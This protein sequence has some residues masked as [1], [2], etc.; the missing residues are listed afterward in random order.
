MSYDNLFREIIAKETLSIDINTL[1][2]D[3]NNI[4]QYYLKN[5]DTVLDTYYGLIKLTYANNA[6]SK[7]YKLNNVIVDTIL[8]NGININN[9]NKNGETAIMIILNDP[10]KYSK[11]DL[12]LLAIYK[13]LSYDINLL[14]RDNNGETVINRL[15]IFE[16]YYDRPRILNFIIHILT[17]DINIT[18]LKKKENK[19]QLILLVTMLANERDEQNL[20]IL[21][22]AFETKLNTNFNSNVYSIIQRYQEITPTPIS[23]RN[24]MVYPR[25]SRARTKMSRL[26][27]NSVPKVD[28]DLF[29]SA[30]KLNDKLYQDE[31]CFCLEMDIGDHSGPMLIPVTRFGKSLEEGYYGSMKKEVHKDAVFTWYYYEPDS[32]FVLLSN[33]TFIAKNKVQ[34]FLLLTSDMPR[35]TQIFEEDEFSAEN[36]EEDNSLDIIKSLYYTFK[37]LKKTIKED[38]KDIK[39]EQNSEEEDSEEE[40]S[41]EEDSE[42]ESDE[43][44]A[45]YMDRRRYNL[46]SL[47]DFEFLD[48]L[49]E[50][51]E[52]PLETSSV[53]NYLRTTSGKVLFEGGAL[54]YLDKQIGN[55]AREKGYEVLILTHQS[56]TY[57]RLV[58]EVLDL[59]PRSVSVG[60]IFSL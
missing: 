10:K 58:S 39:N 1:D 19:D 26:L 28:V 38:I 27:G 4:F 32:D 59:R 34:A 46:G 37:R 8:T 22:K 56:G 52:M 43:E 17:S 3:G 9:Q 12:I 42:E 57:G 25:S 54:D 31:T 35:K 30:I 2:S 5:Y 51:T 11:F 49:L 21:I 33:K 23:R 7:K 55:L 13:A 41:E 29:K 6:D 40:D 45:Y 16:S 20:R 18:E 14:L 47:K 50:N 24:E 36:E 60:N 53:T 48:K 44:Y 15:R